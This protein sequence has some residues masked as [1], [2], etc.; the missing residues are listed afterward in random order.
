MGRC[1]EQSP[2]C[3]CIRTCKKK[4]WFMPHRSNV[5]FV[6]RIPEAIIILFFSIIIG[7]IWVSPA[8][9]P[10]CM[11]CRIIHSPNLFNGSI[12]VTIGGPNEDLEISYLQGIDSWPRPIE[13]LLLKKKPLDHNHLVT[14]KPFSIRNVVALKACV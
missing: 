13:R 14:L 12:H 9:F 1:V 4:A 2:N 10:W 5:A 11:N 6:A 8:N 7:V 3:Y